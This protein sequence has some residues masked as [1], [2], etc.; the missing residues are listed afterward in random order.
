MASPVVRCLKQQVEDCEVH[1]LTEGPFA[2]LMAHNPFIDKV[3]NYNRP[4]STVMDELCEFGFDYVIDLQ[5]NLKTQRIKNR[6]KLINFSLGGTKIEKWILVNFK[7]NLLPHAHIVDHFM[8]TISLFA[9]NDGC[10]LDFFIRK[11]D[12]VDVNQFLYDIHRPFVALVLSAK[13]KT[14]QPTVANLERMLLKIKYPV[15]LLG[16]DADKGLAVDLL[17]LTGNKC[18][19]VCGRYSIYQMASI[20]TQSACVVTGDN[21]FSA[22]ASALKKD[23]VSIWGS[24][25]PEFGYAPYLAG[26]NSQIIEV[27]DLKCRPC[28]RKGFSSCPRG[29]FQCM[30]EID[31]DYVAEVVNRIAAGMRYEI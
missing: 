17:D 6:L 15:V 2:D 30:T 27:K 25:V 20:L 21:D 22:I 31:D 28:S 14:R 7:K 4:F 19:D 13:Y 10:G 18:V 3:H 1:L 9:N 5:K 11:E 12:E 16:S 29:H 24:T 26:Q 23:V 8:K